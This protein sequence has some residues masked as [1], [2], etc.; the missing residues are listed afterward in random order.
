M[1]EQAS[2]MRLRPDL[3]SCSA[4]EED[5]NLWDVSVVL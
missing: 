5:G 2:F 4:K 3:K 1:N